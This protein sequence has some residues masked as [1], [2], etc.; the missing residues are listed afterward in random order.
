LLEARASVNRSE[1]L[2]LD[3]RALTVFDDGVG[4]ALYAGGTFAVASRGRTQLISKGSRTMNRRTIR[5]L[6]VVLA[7]VLGNAVFGL[8]PAAEAD[9]VPIINPGFEDF[10]IFVVDNNSTHILLH[11]PSEIL[12]GD[13]VPGWVLI[14]LGGTF[15]PGSTSF[16]GIPEG[17]NVA[18]LDFDSIESSSL[19]QVLST[20]LSANT[21][22]TLSVDVGHKA[23]YPLAAF[24]VQ[25]LAG[26]ELLGEATLDA[27]P[28]GQFQTVTVTFTAPPDHSQL[29][30]PLAIR[31]VSI[32]DRQE[33][34]FDNVRLDATP[35]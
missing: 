14:G 29:D 8:V 11:S 10:S 13:P 27:I 7:L 1:L 22:Y 25:L 34:C 5:Q 18:W 16:S 35:Q 17:I 12:S 2:A 23:G 24:S 4:P 9:P 3:G 33:V 19:S 30:Q 26:G 6:G 32:A 20:T 15:R 28:E 21:V 31:L